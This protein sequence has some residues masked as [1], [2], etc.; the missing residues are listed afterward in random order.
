[1]KRSFDDIIK[2][3]RIKGY[4]TVY[5]DTDPT[6]IHELEEYNR[7]MEECREMKRSIDGLDSKYCGLNI[8]FTVFMTFVFMTYIFSRPL[9]SIILLA[10][11]VFGIIEFGVL[12][13]KYFICAAISALLIIV[14]PYYFFLLIA[15]FIICV[16]RYRRTELIKAEPG[17]P[18]FLNIRIRFNHGCEN[19]I[20]EE[21]S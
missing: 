5:S 3:A 20:G 13:K 1:M 19:P 17:Y 10:L 16:L 14:H 11:H 15:N 6:L 4:I 12:R 8:I 21:L 18:D 7:H 2:E 9:V